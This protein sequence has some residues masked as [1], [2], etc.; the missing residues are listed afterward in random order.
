MTVDEIARIVAGKAHGELARKITGV[1]QIET[2]SPTDLA[3]ME[4]NRALKRATQS[5]AGC[6]LVP[7][8]TSLPGRTYI[9]V[10]SPKVAFIE[11]AEALS[12]RESHVPGVHP[13]AVISPEAQL[14]PGV[15]AGPHVVIESGAKVGADS[16]VGAG[17]FVGQR[18]EIGSHCALH[19]HVTLYP[20][21]RV[22]NRV[23]LHAG[24]VIGGD[25]FGYVLD[26]GR[27]RKFPQNGGVI[28]E[29]EVEI[30]CN[31]TID[32]GSL[33]STVIGFGTKIDNLVQIAHNVR[34]GCHCVIA[35]QTGISGSSVVGDYVVI[36]GQA[37]IGDHVRIESRAALGGQAGVLPGKV[38]RE[39]AVVWG[40]PARPL[41]EFKKLYAHL[42]SLPELART[43]K[44]ISRARR[45]TKKPLTK[46]QSRQGPH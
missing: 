41:A 3:F 39:G 6:L 32:R 26:R 42:A 36:G 25:G 16:V 9:S 38:V 4:G 24:V 23:V 44:E 37:G 22:G 34:I 30:G 13:T 10:A 12:P 29:D 15:S 46:A 28:I 14:G 19:S 11:A 40:T 17:T 43:V 31:T 2:A 5:K 8:G 1:A 20:G 27:Y 18:A 35:A 7:E 45:K 33:G 21:V